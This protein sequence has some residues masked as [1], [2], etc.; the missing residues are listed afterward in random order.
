[1]QSYK[2]VVL[3]IE[4]NWGYGVAMLFQTVVRK[5]SVV[6]GI[7]DPRGGSHPAL[8]SPGSSVR[9]AHCC[10]GAALDVGENKDLGGHWRRH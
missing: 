2:K 8:T 4:N 3:V 6:I 7:R 10:P 5:G 9:G 1:M